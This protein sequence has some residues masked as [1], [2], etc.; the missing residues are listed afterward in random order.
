MKRGERD[1]EMTLFLRNKTPCFIPPS[2]A[3]SLPF[4]HSHPIPFYPLLQSIPPLPLSYPLLFLNQ[5]QNSESL[6]LVPRRP[7]FKPN[8]VCWRETGLT[9]SRISSIQMT[10]ERLPTLFP[11]FHVPVN[12]TDTHHRISKLTAVRSNQ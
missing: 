4:A 2:L 8:K 10:V 3:P 12:N 9:N 11:V 7:N 1:G 5:V 6:N